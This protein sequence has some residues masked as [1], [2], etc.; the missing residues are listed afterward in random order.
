MEAGYTADLGICTRIGNGDFAVVRT[1]V[2]PSGTSLDA[3]DTQ[4]G[5]GIDVEVSVVDALGCRARAG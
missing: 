1:F 5:E 3:T 4:L 2:N